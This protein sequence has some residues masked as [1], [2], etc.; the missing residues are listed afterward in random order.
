M[1]EKTMSFYGQQL[2]ACQFVVTASPAGQ[3]PLPAR[4]PMP[5]KTVSV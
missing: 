3:T 1:G 5:A 2:F 4:D